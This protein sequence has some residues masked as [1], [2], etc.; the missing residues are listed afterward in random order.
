MGGFDSENYEIERHFVKSLDGK[1]KV[2]VS[3]AFRKDLF[4]TNETNSCL[5]YGYGSYGISI[6]PAFRSNWVTYMDRGFVVAIAHIRGGGDCGKTWYED[7][8]FLKKKNTFEDFVAAA[9]YLV[10]KGITEPKYLVN[11]I[12]KR[13]M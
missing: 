10:Q 5:L 11:Y 7:G 3:L 1:V 6:D 12:P 9:E 2:P 4:K 13:G 8:K